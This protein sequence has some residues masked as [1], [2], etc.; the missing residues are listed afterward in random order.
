MYLISRDVSAIGSLPELSARL[1]EPALEALGQSMLAGEPGSMGIPWGGLDRLALYMPLAAKGLSLAVLIPEE[2]LSRPLKML[3]RQ[4][5]VLTLGLI[6]LTAA[7]LYGITRATLRPVRSLMNMAERLAR[8]DFSADPPPARKR[9][10]PGR[11][12]IPLRLD[13]SGRLIR[14][15]DILRQALRQRL[16]DL[17]LAAAAR[18]R[19][20]SELALAR[21]I[22]EGVRPRIL[23][24]A[25]TLEL[26]ALLRGIHPVSSTLYDAFFRSGRSLCCILADVVAQGIPAALF[27]GRIIPLLRETLLAGALPGQSLET[28]NKI[29]H[30]GQKAPEPPIFAHILAGTLD[31]VSGVF[32]WAGAGPSLPILLRGGGATLMSGAR[33]DPL[34]MRPRSVFPTRSLRL[35]AGDALFLAT[36]G[37]GLARSSDGVAYRQERLFSFLSARAEAERRR[38]AGGGKDAPGAFTRGEA[39][40]RAVLED[41][42]DHAAP[43]DPREDVALLLLQWKGLGGK[44]FLRG[45]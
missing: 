2:T 30:I 25:D 16:E 24:Q 8:G 15:A 38:A 39:L 34:G 29:L 3:G 17:T 35:L 37:L 41:V 18:E 43:E 21:D 9:F 31:T 13:E 26:A 1:G 10:F 5:I 7:G 12:A 36:D 27:M 6:L 22:Q 23:P 4:I 28:V 19:L 32:S 11:P 20:T 45:N 33:G 40:L 44:N 14:A 42:A